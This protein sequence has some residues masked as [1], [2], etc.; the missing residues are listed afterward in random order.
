MQLRDGTR[1]QPPS[2][3]DR[4]LERR[5]RQLRTKTIAR[6]PDAYFGAK[7]AAERVGDLLRGLKLVWMSRPGQSPTPPVR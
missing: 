4:L 6:R 2:E 1:S 3:L 7:C 5:E